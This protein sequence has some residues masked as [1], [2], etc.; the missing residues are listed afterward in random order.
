VVSTGGEVVD[1]GVVDV[2]V[3][4]VAGDVVLV[5]R[6]DV[7]APSDDP[8][9]PHAVPTSARLAIRTQSLRTTLMLRG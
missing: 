1:G 8:P 9:P 7:R 2:V 5:D 6:D 3:D 4:V